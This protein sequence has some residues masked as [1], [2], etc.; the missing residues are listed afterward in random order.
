M[1]RRRRFSFSLIGTCLA[2]SY[3]RKEF[4]WIAEHTGGAVL[5]FDAASLPEAMQQINQAILWRVNR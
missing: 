5:P 1:N 4:A 2:E 3:V